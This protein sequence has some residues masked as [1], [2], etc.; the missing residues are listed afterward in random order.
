MGST[1]RGQRSGLAGRVIA[2][3]TWGGSQQRHTGSQQQQTGPREAR[4]EA[5]PCDARGISTD[6]DG[7][8][9]EG[10]PGYAKNTREWRSGMGQG[11]ASPRSTA[12]HGLTTAGVAE[13]QNRLA[14]PV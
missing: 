3:S 8:R 6:N 5:C 12:H 14:L 10:D 13:P 9:V 2:R 4:K 7:D 11:P 1:G